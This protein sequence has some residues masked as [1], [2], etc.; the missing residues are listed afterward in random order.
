MW[1]LPAVIFIENKVWLARYCFT[2]DLSKTRF[3][4][5]RAVLSGREW[6]NFVV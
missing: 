4:Y 3:M 5:D 2:V 1:G 6:F